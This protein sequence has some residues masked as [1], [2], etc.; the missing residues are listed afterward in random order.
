MTA[1]YHEGLCMVKCGNC[2]RVGHMTRDHKAAVVAPTQMA[3]V[4]NQTGNI[5]YEC[6]RLGHYRNGCPKLR[7]QNCGNKTGN[8]TGNNKA[9]TRA[10]TI[11]R[12]GASPDSNVIMGTFLLNNRYATMLF[13]SGTDRSFMSTTFSALLDVIPST[14]D[15]S[16]VIELADERIS[17]TNVIL[18]GC[19]L[20]LLG[21]SFNID[22]MPIEFGSFDVIVGMDWL[23]K[24]HTVIVCDKRIVRIPY[25]DEVLII[26]G[27]GYKLTVKNRYLLSRID[28]LFDQLQGLRVY[29]KIDLRSGY[30]QLRFHKEDIP[31]T[32]FRTR[33]SHYEFQVMLFGLTN[34]LA[35]FMDLM[36]WV[37]KPYLDKFVI[38]FIDDILIYSKNKKEHEGYLK[39]ILRLLKKEKLFAKFSKCEFWLSIVKFLGHVIDSK[40]THIDLAKIESVKDWASPNTPT[41]IFQFLGLAEKKEAAFQLLKQKLCSAPILA[42]PEGS[43]NFVVYYDAS[44][45]GLGAVLMQR[46]KLI[47]YAS[48]QLKVNEKNY[49]THDLELRAHI[50]DQKELNMRQRRWLE[51][52]S[53]YDCEIRYHPGK[54]NQILN[55]Q[56]EARK[57]DNYITKDLHCMIN[58]LKARVD[59]RYHT[60]IKVAP[61]EALYRRK[62]RSPI[63]WAEVGDSQITGPEIIHDTTEKIIQIKSRIQ[64]AHDRQKSYANVRWKPLEFQMGDKVMLKVSPWKGVIR[65]SKRGKLNPRYIR[66]FKILAKVGI[67]AYRLEL[68]EQL[69]RVYSMFHVS[70]LKKC[71]F[72]KTLGIPLDEIQIDD[73]L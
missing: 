39:L 61:F 42:L 33:Y 21:H 64:A 53:D 41:R 58:K 62:F 3:P 22:L 6:G 52:L 47:T 10:Y 63:C 2:K 59:R 34:A 19:T 38:V 48:R 25:G 36:N 7:N 66:P 12:G 72:E 35:I 40:G 49:T 11:G 54:A 26:K 70:N 27:D 31:K 30:H 14:L 45:K 18:R 32:T 37:C 20:G 51:L 73:K 17:K 44:H 4:G 13:D 56:V 67:V 46:E 65:F 50:L 28:D 23:A 71:L 29:S 5:C 9:K 15:T 69:S 24:Y 68:P 57:E 55:A 16:Y 60:S 1:S 8:K 43:E